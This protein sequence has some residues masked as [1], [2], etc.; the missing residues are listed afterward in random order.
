[1]PLRLFNTL[2]RHLE[3]FEPLDPET[4]R[5]YTC[6]PTVYDVPHIGNLRT[7][8]FEDIL[9]RTLHF[10]GYDVEQVMNLTDVEDKIIA[11]AIE[12]GIG[13]DELTAP[14][15]DA[16]FRD[17]DYLHVERV[18]RY[19]RATEHVPEMVAL[20]ETLVEKGHAYQ[21]DGSVYFRI[22]TDD[23]Y[24]RLSSID[25]SQV[26][27]GE[28]VASDEYGKD[29]ARDFVLWKAAKEG[30]PTWDSPW[31]PGRPGWH[32]ECSAM[33]MKY[34][35]ETFD[36]H[37]GGVDNIFP[38]HDNEIAQSESVT[39]RPFARYWLHAEHLLVDGQKMSKSLRNQ[40]TLGEL[41]ERGLDPRAI[42]YLFLSVH[43]RQ[44][45]N[46]TFDSVDKATAALRRLDEMQFRV[47]AAEERELGPDDED[48]SVVEDAVERLRTD[49]TECLADDLNTS[50]ALG[51]LFTF[52]KDVNV[53]VENGEL[54]HGD[55]ARVV[56]ALADVDRVLGV[57]DASA[58]RGETAEEG[59]DD[60][61]IERLIEERA[62]AR[63][64][65]DFAEADRIR[66]ELT[67]QGVVLE[68]TAQ[69]TRWKRS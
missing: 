59:L 11:L 34:L 15:T 26:R 58:W 22:A 51:A 23:D 65:R 27:R 60:V 14:F 16:F 36:I 54:V 32:I 68:D 63:R 61:E 25:L 19:P 69:G 2:G 39:G 18:E 42:R 66:D 40:Y 64:A 41:R 5:I 12:R 53:A 52:V 20:I 45:L 50:G 37:C 49:F 29:D 28:R 13:I 48:R 43:Y 57:L 3:D 10:L 46:F 21:S 7:F 31:G 67:S 44:K 9:R 38:H 30:E 56:I 62:A 6:G 35:G 33:S 8:V 24:G 17:L 1:V 47:G 55:R 4:V